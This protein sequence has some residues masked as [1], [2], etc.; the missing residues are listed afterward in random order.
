MKKIS[1]IFL[2]LLL[3]P[4]C[5]HMTDEQIFGEVSECV[6]VTAQMPVIIRSDVW[7]RIEYPNHIYT[8]NSDAALRHELV[9]YLLNRGG[10]ERQTNHDHESPKFRECALGF[11]ITVR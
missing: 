7:P 9:H 10:I 11:A 4:G 8:N 1:P 6:G 2:L 5:A 3:L